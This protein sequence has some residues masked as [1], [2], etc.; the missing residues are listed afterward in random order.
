MLSVL[1][2]LQECADITK[3]LLIGA[4]TRL[5]A[6]KALRDRFGIPLQLDFYEPKALQ[7]IITKN[8][9]KGDFDI[10]SEG[11]GNSKKI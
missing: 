4:T 9:L 2:Q 11:I 10:D 1:V 7:I 6:F 8:S 5:F 3:N